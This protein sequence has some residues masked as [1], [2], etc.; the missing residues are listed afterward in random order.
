MIGTTLVANGGDG[1]A[2]DQV[3]GVRANQGKELV[4]LIVLNN[5]PSEH[6]HWHGEHAHWHGEH[7]FSP[8][9]KERNHVN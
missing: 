3:G 7:D 1:A 6:A 8:C 9:N 4:E 5:T 2:L